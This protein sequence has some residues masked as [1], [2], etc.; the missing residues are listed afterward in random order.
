MQAWTNVHVR[1]TAVKKN[2]KETI[3]NKDFTIQALQSEA[4]QGYCCALDYVLPRLNH[5]NDR[6]RDRA[7]RA[8]S[9][10]PIGRNFPGDVSMT[11]ESDGSQ[12]SD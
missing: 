9:V 5:E 3:L 4:Q 10:T 11:L 12:V 8:V 6:P 1:R 2:R 7:E